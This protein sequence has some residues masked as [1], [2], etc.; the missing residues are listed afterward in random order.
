M[1]EDVQLLKAEV[2]HLKAKVAL[3][4]KRLEVDHVYVMDDTG[5]LIRKDVPV[6]DR[7]SQCDAVDCRDATIELV[8]SMNKEL[9]ALIEGGRKKKDYTGDTAWTPCSHEVTR[10]S[11]VEELIMNPDALPP[12]LRGWRRFRIEYGFECSCPEGLIY[13]PAEVDPDDIEFLLQPRRSGCNL[14]ELEEENEN[15]ETTQQ[16]EKQHDE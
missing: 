13:M 4:E 9:R 6:E 10:P 16:K 8:E 5:R 1:T 15:D 7:T 12:S 14:N 3:Y 11:L 2:S